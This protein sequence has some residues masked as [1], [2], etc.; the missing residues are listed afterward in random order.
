MKGDAKL[1]GNRGSNLDLTGSPKNARTHTTW[2]RDR[3]LPH[4][5]H[6]SYNMHTYIININ[7]V[8]IILFYFML[9]ILF[10]A[11]IYFIIYFVNLFQQALIYYLFIHAFILG[12]VSAFNHTPPSQSEREGEGNYNNQHIQEITQFKN[13]PYTHNLLLPALA[14]PRCS[15][16]LK[17]K[18]SGKRQP[19]SLNN[20]LN[21]S[22]PSA[23]IHQ[24]V[25][26]EETSL[27]SKQ[28]EIFKLPSN[29]SQPPVSRFSNSIVEQNSRYT[30]NL[31][32]SECW[33]VLA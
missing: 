32:Q 14:P 15:P 17:S 22:N 28:S 31:R 5:K 7:Y 19:A 25:S 33:L 1:G 16:H 13:P 30:I 2:R 26:L 21:P 8:S 20:Q 12:C 27:S 9:F 3:R 11:N 4:L 24:V 23:A 29:A 6:K 18:K 10:Y